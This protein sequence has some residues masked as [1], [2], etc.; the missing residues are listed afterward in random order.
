MIKILFICHGNICRSPMA[1]F[2][3]KDMVQ[4]KGW[5][6]DFR[7]SSAATTTEEIWN[8]VG[9]PIYSPAAKCLEKHGVSYSK[10][11][12][13]RLLKAEDYRKYD[14]LIGMDSENRY[15]MRRIL[16]EDA[17]GKM[18][19]LLDFTEGGGDVADPWYTRDFE[20]TYRDIVEGC[21]AFLSTIRTE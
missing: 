10:E 20:V 19:L 5:Q 16:G 21:K 17:E 13:A 11:K 1:E 2:I 18:H 9:N 8:G 12:R 6:E 4:K 3:L 7:I 15:D 14:Y